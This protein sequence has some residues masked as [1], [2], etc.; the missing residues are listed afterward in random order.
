MTQQ[1]RIQQ[2][3]KLME[4]TQSEM[5]FHMGVTQGTYSFYEK[6]RDIPERYH[7]ILSKMGVNLSWLKTGIGEP[8]DE[9]AYLQFKKYRDNSEVSVV[10]V[11]VSPNVV[12]PFVRFGFR[13]AVSRGERIKEK[14]IIVRDDN[15]DYTDAI[16]VEAGNENM[17]PTV[18]PGEKLLCMPV[19]NG[20]VNYVTGVVL[21]VFGGMV[22]IRR[23]KTNGSEGDIIVFTSDNSDETVSVR[24]EDISIMYRVVMSVGRPIA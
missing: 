13:Q 8:I 1:E 2:V 21:V 19:E 23:V 4:L 11:R 17:E 22:S 20:S 10:D 14:T 9:E 15:V 18:L 6:N 7:P 16:V 5:A 24:K 3:R 12:L